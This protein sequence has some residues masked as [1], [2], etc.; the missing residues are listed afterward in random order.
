MSATHITA[1][2]RRLVWQRAAGC[3]EY[4][5]IHESEVLLP[6]EA[7]HVIAEQHGGRTNETNLAVACFQCNKLKG[8]NL[9]AVDLVTGGIELL[10]H[11][12]L[13]E[14]REHFVFIGPRIETLTPR[15]RATLN[16]LRFNAPERLR[17]RAAL[18]EGG[19]CFE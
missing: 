9:S 10:F 12:R 13:H 1:A 14:W 15:G 8:P 17:L 16:L 2:L 11:P 18:I 7:D 19:R 4:C 6:H 3:C 5:R